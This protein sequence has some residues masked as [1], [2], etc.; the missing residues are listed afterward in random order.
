MEKTPSF[1]GNMKSKE[2]HKES[3]Y[4][5][6][7]MKKENMIKFHSLKQA[8]HH[9]FDTCGHCLKRTGRLDAAKAPNK[10]QYIGYFCIYLNGSEYCNYGDNNIVGEIPR[11]II[12]LRAKLYSYANNEDPIENSS[13]KF[14]YFPDDINEKV[15]S[16]N[17][18]DKDGVAEIQYNP[19]DLEHGVTKFRAYFPESTY[20][21]DG[22][23]ESY[24]DMLIDF[25]PSIK[26]IRIIPISFERS[27]TIKFDL[28]EN[29]VMD[30]SIYKNTNFSGPFSHRKTIRSYKDGVLEKGNDIEVKWDGTNDKNKQTWGGNYVVLL[31]TPKDFVPKGGLYKSK[32]KFGK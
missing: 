25:L 12:T 30:I 23:V 13:I 7:L 11:D 24:M 3:C 2:T 21:N 4:C 17:N 9:G 18:T 26:N 28:L 20:F 22:S 8:V 27:T 16:I 31:K 6:K 10:Y 14:T 5:L 32:G 15:I 19:K 29:T 1:I